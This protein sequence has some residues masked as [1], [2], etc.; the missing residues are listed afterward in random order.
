[1]IHQ[2]RRVIK[3]Y[4]FAEVRHV[5]VDDRCLRLLKEL[6]VNKIMPP[7]CEM[8]DLHEH[9]LLEAIGRRRNCYWEIKSINY[10]GHHCT[11][12][13]YNTFEIVELGLI[14]NRVVE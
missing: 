4:S 6:I 14:I 5:S 13:D 1:M 3:K 10:K 11:R 7:D 12:I 2:K 9:E 8:D